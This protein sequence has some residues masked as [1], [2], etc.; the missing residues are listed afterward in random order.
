MRVLLLA[1]RQWGQG[2]ALLGRMLTSLG[3]GGSVDGE[4]PTGEEGDGVGDDGGE[5]GGAGLGEGLGEGLGVGVGFGVGL[6]LGLGVGLDAGEGDDAGD[7]ARD[8][9]G[10]G[11]GREGDGAGAGDGIGDGVGEG[12]D[13]GAAA[14]LPVVAAGDGD[15][16][17]AGD[18]AGEGPGL[19]EAAAAALGVVAGPAVGH[20]DAA[21]PPVKGT[22][23]AC[24]LQQ[25]NTD[26]RRHR[27]NADRLTDWRRVAR[28]PKLLHMHCANADLMMQSLCTQPACA[29]RSRYHCMLP[30]T[31]HC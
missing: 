5:G 16:G 29:K 27:A 15:A 6:E 20:W 12:G 18:A 17:G 13:L 14:T 24:S 3:A 23:H 7:G 31:R 30:N 10:V 11:A 2:V 19:G 26:R 21:E 9:A 4:M 8:G 1:I 22:P 25:E 28:N